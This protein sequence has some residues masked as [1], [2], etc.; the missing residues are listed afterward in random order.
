MTANFPNVFAETLVQHTISLIENKVLDVAKFEEAVFDEM[1]QTAGG[2]NQNVTASC[3]FLLLMTHHGSTINNHRLEN[4]IV[5]EF[6]SFIV[7]LNSQFTSRRHNNHLRLLTISSN[8]PVDARLEK[9]VDDGHQISSLL[10]TFIN[11]LIL[12]HKVKR[13]NKSSCRVSLMRRVQNTITSA[14]VP[15]RINLPPVQTLGPSISITKYRPTSAEDE[16][17]EQS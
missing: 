4:G 16:G 12:V 11:E 8:T 7:D 5:R 17:V 1:V 3:Q 9:N 15:T 2:P 13:K 10:K 6:A 14:D